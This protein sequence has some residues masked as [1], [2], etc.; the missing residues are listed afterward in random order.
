MSFVLSLTFQPGKFHF[1]KTTTT[2]AS[3]ITIITII[4][5][6]QREIVPND[7]EDYPLP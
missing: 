3:I 4:I 5:T 6:M 1:V 7:Q 2:T